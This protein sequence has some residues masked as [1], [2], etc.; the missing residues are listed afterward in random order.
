MK[1]GWETWHW[2]SLKDPPQKTLISYNTHTHTHTVTS[3]YRN[4][5]N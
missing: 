4:S 3:G 5:E 1:V 2:P